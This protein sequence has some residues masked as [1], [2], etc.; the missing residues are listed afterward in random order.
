MGGIKGFQNEG[1][2]VRKSLSRKT[3]IEIRMFARVNIISTL[4]YTQ[5]A[6]EI[7]IF[8][9]QIITFMEI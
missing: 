4:K 5:F 8:E 1:S 2:Q 9:S 3:A 6:L 7:R